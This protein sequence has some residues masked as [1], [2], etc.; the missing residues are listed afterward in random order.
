MKQ[1]DELAKRA[2]AALTAGRLA[3]AAELYREARWLLPA[4]PP[5]FPENVA[6]VFGSPRLR[7]ADRIEDLAFSPDGS[8]LATASKDGMVKLWDVAT[9]RALRVIRGGGPAALLNPTGKSVAV[10]LSPDGK[11]LAFAAGNIIQLHET[12]SGKELRKLE[13]HTAAVA[14]LAFSPDG[15]TLASG[16]G[17]KSVRT[18]EVESGKQLGL[19]QGETIRVDSV[20]FNA[21]GDLLGS[22]GGDGNFRVWEHGKQRVLVGMQGFRKG[23]GTQIAFHPDGKRLALCGPEE[24]P[25]L[26]E[27]PSTGSSSP[28]PGRS[29]TASRVIRGRCIAWPSA[30]T[31]SCW[32]PAARTAPSASGTWPPTRRSARFRAIW[33]K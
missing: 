12:D 9:G 24:P 33:M 31:A 30:R 17:D 16:S 11:T 32:P 26:R 20:A 21:G 8:L 1:A 10:A 28:T 7:H 4:L 25:Q 2:E 27:P 5:D 13:G 6:R 3:E 19:F 22:V 15:K 23:G 29:C 14:S 18:W